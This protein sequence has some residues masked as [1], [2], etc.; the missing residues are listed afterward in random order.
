MQEMPPSLPLGA[1]G[2]L[3]VQPL[4]NST[5]D[6]ALLVRQGPESRALITGERAD[7]RDRVVVVPLDDDVQLRVDGDALAVWLTRG[8]V[9][10]KPARAP[11]WASAIGLLLVLAFVAF[12]LIG[13][14]VSVRWLLQALA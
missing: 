5:G 9:T 2:R 11:A 12:A 10:A 1:T 13:S 14:V 8:S 6:H 4:V 7:A 3:E